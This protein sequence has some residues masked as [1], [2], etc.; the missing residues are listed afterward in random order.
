MTVYA[1]AQ[2]SIHNPSRYQQYVSDFMS[3]LTPY[4]GI[5]LV[6]QEN[7]DVIEGEWDNDKI[8]IISFKD[9][10]SLDAWAGSPEYQEISKSRIAATRGVVLFVN[11][12]DQ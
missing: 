6:A 9:R 8:V 12:F 5:L 2:F 10:Q 1:I 3:V 7:P 4:G 11:G